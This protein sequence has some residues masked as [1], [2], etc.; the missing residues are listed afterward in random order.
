MMLKDWKELRSDM[1]K[2]GTRF[3][4]INKEVVDGFELHPILTGH[5]A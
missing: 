1:A 2:G 5:P 3:R 4:K